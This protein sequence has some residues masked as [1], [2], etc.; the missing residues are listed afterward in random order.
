MKLH[1]P[2]RQQ[3]L[4]ADVSAWSRFCRALS[5]YTRRTFGRKNTCYFL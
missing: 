2:A 5:L 1:A 4:K 3:V